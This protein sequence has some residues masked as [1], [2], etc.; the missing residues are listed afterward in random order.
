MIIKKLQESC[1]R[2]FQINRLIVYQ[3]FLRQIIFL[4]T[5][6][7]EFQDIEVWFTGQNS[8]P[9]EKEGRITLTLGIK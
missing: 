7:L 1:T 9:L 8:Q 2:L 4:K 3:K 5:I 6:N